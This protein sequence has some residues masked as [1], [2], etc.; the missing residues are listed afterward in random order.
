MPVERGSSLGPY[1]IQFRL[2][3]GGM[4]EVWRAR[5]TRSGREVAIKVISEQAVGDPDRLS[6]FVS[7]AKSAMALHHPNILT[8]H[9]IGESA[10][11]PYIVMEYV[12]GGTVRSL[13]N[14]G[15]LPVAQAVDIAM[16]AADGVASAHGAGIVHRDLKPDN[17]M[18]T[19]GGVVKILDFGLARSLRPEDAADGGRTA[20]GMIVGTAAYVSPEQLRG[21][22]ATERS[23][24]FALGVVLFEM[25]T[26]ENPFQRNN[27]IEM[28]SAILRDDPPPLTERAPDAPEELSRTVSRA[29][30]KKPQ[31]R[32]PT[33]SELAADLRDV[34][35]VTAAPPAEILP[36]PSPATA[37]RS[38]TML[39]FAGGLLALLVGAL[40]LQRG[41]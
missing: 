14:D 2:G 27:P 4:G 37:S 28:F 25:T 24:V 26:G 32:H 33:A 39:V 34:H 8:V 40:L 29:L 6:R 38:L 36:E 30:A 21:E 41:C 13:L 15:R 20:A 16:Q 12:D 10:F 18:I 7:E 11:G 5:D 22:K 3:G 1:Q 23:D 19:S 17:L 31:D 9:E 35:R